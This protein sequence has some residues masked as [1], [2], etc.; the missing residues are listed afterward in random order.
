MPCDSDAGRLGPTAAQTKTQQT[1][2]TGLLRHSPKA[3]GLPRPRAWSSQP[4]T[5]WES[6]ITTWDHYSLKRLTESE[7]RTPACQTTY[8]IKNESPDQVNELS[9]R[10]DLRGP[11][12]HALGR[13]LH[14]ARLCTTP[15]RETHSSLLTQGMDARP[16]TINPNSAAHPLPRSGGQ[17]HSKPQP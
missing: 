1:F 11:Q 6:Q 3:G 4:A 15:T 16:P 9:Y 2:R 13:A 7:G 14:S 17:A 5:A 12:T 8:V 10:A